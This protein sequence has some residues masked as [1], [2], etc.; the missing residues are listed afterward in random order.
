MMIPT[1][2]EANPSMPESQGMRLSERIGA[3]RRVLQ[4]D[5]MDNGLKN[6]LWNLPYRCF[7]TSFEKQREFVDL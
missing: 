4:K 2:I 1:P 3:V 7:W 5:S 6:S